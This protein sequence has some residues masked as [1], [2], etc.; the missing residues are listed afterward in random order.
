[1]RYPSIT[2]QC[3]YT[4]QFIAF[5]LISM[6]IHCNIKRCLE[7]LK[8]SSLNAEVFS[9]LVHS[10]HVKHNLLFGLD[11]A[12]RSCAARRGCSLFI[13][14]YLTKFGVPDWGRVESGIGLS[15]GRRATC[16]RLAGPI[17]QLYAIVDYIPRS[18]NKNIATLLLVH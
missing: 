8:M 13:V 9:Y 15:T 2:L 11:C 1:M 18:R 12:M 7:M 5:A 16:C 6:Y 4:G 3:L 10:C 17:Q 14:L